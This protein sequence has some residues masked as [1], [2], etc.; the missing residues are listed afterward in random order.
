MVLRKRVLV[1]GG[2]GFIGSQLCDRSRFG[3]FLFARLLRVARNTRHNLS[4]H[5]NF[6][7]S[8]LEIAGL[9]A[10]GNSLVDLVASCLDRLEPLATAAVAW[11]FPAN[12]T[13]RLA[14]TIPVAES[15]IPPG[16]PPD[17]VNRT[18]WHPHASQLPKRLISTRI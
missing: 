8:S 5:L 1:Y 16:A 15:R 17:P 13:A 9:S 18:R 4:D 14:I 6:P 3:G 12:T 7:L 11:S 10:A 2:V